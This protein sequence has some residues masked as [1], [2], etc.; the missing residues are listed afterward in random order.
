MTLINIDDYARPVNTISYITNSLN[1]NIS[2]V[3]IW[4]ILSNIAI[5]KITHICFFLFT[6]DESLSHNESYKLEIKC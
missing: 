1:G 2:I 3:L 5:I 6:E 4:L